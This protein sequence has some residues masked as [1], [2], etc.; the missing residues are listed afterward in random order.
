M[1][2][3]DKVSEE[4]VKNLE[5]AKITLR[6]EKPLIQAIDEPIYPLEKKSLNKMLMA[7]M[8]GLISSIFVV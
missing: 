3:A 2:T 1:G 4:I 7:F 6:K 5:M 8:I